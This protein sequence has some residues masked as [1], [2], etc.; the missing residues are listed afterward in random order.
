MQTRQ[1]PQQAVSRAHGATKQPAL[2]PLHRAAHPTALSQPAMTN[3]GNLTPTD[4]L[5]LQRTIGNQAVGQLLAQATQHQSSQT[6]PSTTTGLPGPLKSGIE[7]I[8]GISMDGVK[9]HYNSAK[10]AQLNALAYTQGSDIHVAPGQERH[11][12]HEAWHLVQQAEG[13]VKPTLQ[14]KDGVAINDD[15]ALEHEA[16]VMGAK[17]LG[18]A[19]QLRSAAHEQKR[20]CGDYSQLE[21]YTHPLPK[22]EDAVEMEAR[23]HRDGKK[24]APIELALRLQRTSP[25]VVQRWRKFKN[26]PHMARN[27]R[28][29][30]T[31]SAAGKV[32][33]IVAENLK[34]KKWKK[35]VK[36]PDG[37]F[38]QPLNAFSPLQW[39]FLNQKTLTHP[40]PP[41]YVRMHMLN[42]RLGGPGTIENL[43]P[44]THSLNL[45]HY[46]NFEGPA[47]D[48][49]NE[50][51]TIDR[52][53][54]KI[55]YNTESKHLKKPAWKKAWK[56][57]IKEIWGKFE[58]QDR[59]GGKRRKVS[60]DYNAEEDAGLDNK[61]NWKSH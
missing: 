46:K 17:A 40:N 32:T 16:D 43:A 53:E 48:V 60:R 33:K 28:W 1:S 44:G 29:K 52:Y 51:R 41:G 7:A 54:V 58:Y 31:M 45:N 21:S 42:D 14:L 12:P 25:L 27:G 5:Q 30:P 57:T 49:L 4:V 13:R 56:H 3:L 9:V 55:N 20:F 10:P 61:I 39:Y 37:P 6:P 36:V 23:P 26:V 47:I 2:A 15:A 34:L 50:G 35:G 59:L 22:A 18:T 19:A 38:N 8:S 11:L 24:R